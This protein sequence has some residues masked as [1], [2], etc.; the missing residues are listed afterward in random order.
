[1]TF[2]D[3]FQV[4]LSSPTA[5]E[6]LS[7]RKKVG[8]QNVT[9]NKVQTSLANSLFHV[10]IYDNSQ[11]VAMG[12]VVGDGVM[13]FYIQ[14]VVVDPRYQGYGLGDTIMKAIEA[15]LSEAAGEGATIGLLAAKGKETFYARYGYLA[16]PN[17]SLGNGMCKFV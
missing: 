16:R 6:F 2:I 15:Y 1:M 10:V 17:T 8:W 11:L 4:K 13:Y 14:D 9:A 3:N 7:L 12:R 5:I